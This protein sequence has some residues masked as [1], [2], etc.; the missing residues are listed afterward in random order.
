MRNTIQKDK[1][2]LS[3]KRIDE[4]NHLLFGELAKGKLTN[5]IYMAACLIAFSAAM[6][7]LIF[8]VIIN[9]SDLFNITIAFIAVSYAIFYYFARFKNLY[10]KN[11]FV[12]ISQ[13]GLALSW[14]SEGGLSGPVLP[15]FIIAIIVFTA[16]SD[17]K[18][19]LLYLALSVGNVLLLFFLEQSSFGTNII[20]YHDK[21][22]HDLDITYTLII[23]VISIFLFAK[24]IKNSFYKEQ[25]II[26]SQKKELEQL[27]ATKDKFFSIIAHDLRG[28]FNGIMGLSKIMADDSIDMSKEELQ[29]LASKLSSSASSTYR[30]LENLLNWAKLK[31]GHIPYEPKKIHLKSFASKH[32]EVMQDIA[33]VKNLK[34][35]NKIPNDIEVYADE[36]MLQTIIRNFIL[37][38]IK[39][40][41]VGGEVKIDANKKTESQVEISIIDNGI[42]MDQKTIDSIFSIGNQVRR[43]GT[44]N[45]PSSGLGLLLCKEFIEQHNG[46]ISIKSK[47]GEGSTF[48]FTIR[49]AS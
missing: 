41:Q 12:L 16:I 43:R 2:I 13:L 7:G 49:M 4:I 28:P 30:L 48:S 39:F 20:Q 32:L 24:F 29:D 34:T 23:A 6:A 15:L 40:T 27:N 5:H 17:P 33:D 45:E 22:S 37:N 3:N 19:H 26:V 11:T 10:F 1:N 25:E 47:P 44:E 42:G 36:Y 21:I 46:E 14:Y 9:L 38:A 18:Y 8:N 31:Q 35:A